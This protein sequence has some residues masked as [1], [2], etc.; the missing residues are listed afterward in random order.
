MCLQYFDNNFLLLNTESTLDPATDPMSTRGP[1]AGPADMFSRFRQ[2]HYNFRSHGTN[3]A[4]SA[5]AHATCRFWC[6]P[7]LFGIQAHNSIARGSGQPSFVGGCIAGQP[8]EVHQMWALAHAPLG[9]L[10]PRAGA[11]ERVWA[12]TTPRGRRPTA[13]G[14]TAIKYF[15]LKKEMVEG[16]V[17]GGRR[18]RGINGKGK[19]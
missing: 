12:A 9:S 19:K 1:T 7:D 4:K 16:L 6:F 5:W 18:N 11:K 17:G 13:T 15:S 14:A 8:P 10:C 3:S 2:P